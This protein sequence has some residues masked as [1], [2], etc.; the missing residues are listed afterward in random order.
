MLSFLFLFHLSNFRLPFGTPDRLVSHRTSARLFL[1]RLHTSITLLTTEAK[2]ADTPKPHISHNSLQHYFDNQHHDS[3]LYDVV[4]L[5][6]PIVSHFCIA[7]WFAGISVP[8]LV[9][10]HNRIGFFLLTFK[11]CHFFNTT[12]IVHIIKIFD[13]IY[14]SLHHMQSMN[15]ESL[16]LLPWC[17]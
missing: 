13:I 9:F 5:G 3:I 8:L 11:D 7:S 2:Y 10:Q 4:S 1:L 16:T 15:S 17:S 6:L 12:K 14:I